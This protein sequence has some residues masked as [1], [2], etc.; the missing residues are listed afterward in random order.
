MKINAEQRK[1]LADIL[2]IIA[3]AQFAVLGYDG[4]VR[5]VF[6]TLVGSGL[7]FALLICIG[8]YVL[9]EKK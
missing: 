8:I 4:F 9:E 2:K 7:V 1:Y 3:V 6:S 5:S